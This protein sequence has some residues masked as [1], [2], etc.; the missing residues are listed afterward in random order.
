M[1]LDAKRIPLFSLQKIIWIA[2]SFFLVTI[3]EAK[4]EPY[5]NNGGLV[6]AIAGKDFVLLASDTRLSD[7]YEIRSR[8]FLS[9]RI[10]VP[11]PSGSSSE[12]AK[13][14]DGDGSILIPSMSSS[15]NSEQK[16]SSNFPNNISKIYYKN[17]C[18]IPTFI[19]SSGCVADCIALQR[20]LRAE[21]SAYTYWAGSRY[22]FPHVQ[23]SHLTPRQV[24][25]LLMNTLYGRRNFP[26]YAFCIV[27]GLDSIQGKNVED[28]QV[29]KDSHGAVYVYD[30]IGSNERVSVAAVG[31]GS[32]MMQ[33]ILDRLFA[34]S[35]FSSAA[36]NADQ[37]T[38]NKDEDI[39]S[40]ND[41]GYLLSERDGNAVAAWRQKKGNILLP[42]VQ[43][44]V[45]CSCEDA[46]NLVMRGYRSVA[47]REIGVGDDVVFCLLRRETDGR[48]SLE[49]RRFPLR[50]H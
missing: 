50:K 23:N 25:V 36:I 38:N 29:E 49:T 17:D 28:E 40:G 24:S 48:H 4:F 8:S 11:T 44:R 41:S 9:S 16:P 43:T 3:I 22:N 2:S 1:G 42:P 26:F 19:G 27:A 33:P 34:T 13:I 21:I 47:E 6:T 46:V 5:Q 45:S 14:F 7:G 12:Y 39:K 10:W 20:Q 30:A 32:Q 35:N 18:D 15:L 31:A 37:T